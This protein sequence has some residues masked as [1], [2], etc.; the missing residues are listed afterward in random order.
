MKPLV[1]TESTTEP[2]ALAAVK[3]NLR[4]TSDAEDSRIA[5]L[6]TAARR[7]CERELELS[8][9]EKTLEIARRSLYPCAIELPQGP[10]RSIVSVKYLDDDGADTTLAADQYRISAYDSP[11]ML[12]PVYDVTW[13]AVRCDIDSV[14]IRYTA[15]YPSDDSPAD[16]VPEPIC[17]AMHLYVAH[18]YA[19]REAVADDTLAEL[20][21]GVRHLL[22]TYRAG[23]GV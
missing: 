15:G 7:M 18:F 3:L 6:I 22:S 14:R 11:T 13:P 12:R 5:S 9:V 21:L 19:N 17:Q 16:E 10:V 8:L 20:P 1:I 23:L 2:L 4:V